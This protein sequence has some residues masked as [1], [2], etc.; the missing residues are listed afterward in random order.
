MKLKDVF[1]S[2]KSLITKYASMEDIISWWELIFQK[3]ELDVK[4]KEA[5]IKIE[6]SLVSAREHIFKRVYLDKVWIEK[7]S[8]VVLTSQLTYQLVDGS[9]QRFLP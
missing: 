5:V 2:S 7:E 4:I 1:N 9:L 6:P 3:V 8:P